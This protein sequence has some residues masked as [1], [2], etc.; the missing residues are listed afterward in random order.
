MVPDAWTLSLVAAFLFTVFTGL[1]VSVRRQRHTYPGSSQ[2]IAATALLALGMFGVALRPARAFWT[3]PVFITAVAL[4]V[5]GNRAFRGLRPGVWWVRLAAATTVVAAAYAHYAG[6]P[7][8][9]ISVVS[10]FLAVAGMISAV[11]L[12]RNPPPEY[13]R[14]L[15]FT[16]AM[17][18]LFAVTYITRAVYAQSIRRLPVEPP[19]TDV[20]NSSFA[21]GAFFIIGPLIFFCCSIGWLMMICERQVAE[22]KEQEARARSL[23]ETAVTAEREK[24]SLM[25]MMGHEIRNPLSA[26]LNLTDLVLETELTIEQREYEIAVRTCIAAL[27][28]VTDDVLNLSNIESDRLEIESSPFDVVDLIEA[29][30][31]VFRPAALRKGVELVVD[32]DQEMHRRFL[33]DDGRIRQ[34]LTNLVGNA[35]KFTG[36]GRISIACR[37]LADGG[38]G[39]RISV[40]DTGI[41]IPREVIESVF[42]RFG[43]AHES[44]SQAYGGAGIG[45][46]ISKSLIERM[47]GRLAVDSEAGKGSTFWFELK[48][49]AAPQAAEARTIQHGQ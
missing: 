43:S 34:V 32:R 26:V 18:L 47:G 2:W 22:L 45:L 6:N 9:R 37:R 29:I 36:E 25:A 1:S 49:P 10:S 16:G 35:V 21:G 48:L 13:N 5:E 44:T 24:A 38:G 7:N 14:G 30:A 46:Q 28:R 41:G 27:L 20:F 12:L 4:S 8:L 31:K 42:E 23:A 19:L 39:F 33:G 15:R 11:T 40:A 17:F 3:I